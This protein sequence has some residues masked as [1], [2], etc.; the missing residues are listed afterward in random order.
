MGKCTNTYSITLRSKIGNGIQAAEEKLTNKESPARRSEKAGVMNFTREMVS[1]LLMAFIAIVYVIQAFRIPTGSME[2]SLLVGDFL[3]G[4]KFMYGAP[5]LPFVYTKFPGITDPK[6][7]D[8]VIFKYPGADS[9]DY[10]KRCVGLPGDTVELK[11]DILYVNDEPVEEPYRLLETSYV[12]HRANFGPVRVPEGNLFMLGDN[13]HNSSDSRVWGMLD[14]KYL[15][16][17]AMVIYFS[18]D[19]DKRFPR[20][21][22]MGKLIH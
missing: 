10:I 5:V 12:G 16:G 9:K 1:A 15:K 6:P 18:W 19:F 22:R 21:T 17:K 14:M 2:N 4:L 8:I 3:L 11:N 13:R 20:F 7:G